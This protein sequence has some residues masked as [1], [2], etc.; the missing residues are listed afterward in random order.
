MTKHNNWLGEFA[1]LFHRDTKYD[2]DRLSKI[3][4]DGGAGEIHISHFTTA[5]LKGLLLKNN[6]TI[7]DD[8]LDPYYPTFGI[9]R[10]LD[11]IRYLICLFLKKVFGVNIYN[12]IW[13]AAKRQ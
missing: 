13:I 7:I 9:A 3:R 4:L 10:C 5:V 8:T 11:D 1:S 2:I 12:T 6:F